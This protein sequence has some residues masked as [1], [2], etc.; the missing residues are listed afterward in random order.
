ME[1]SPE[2]LMAGAVVGLGV[3]WLS[4][5]AAA[6]KAYAQGEAAELKRQVGPAPGARQRF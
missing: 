5:K 4:Q 2:M 3:W 6:E 1:L